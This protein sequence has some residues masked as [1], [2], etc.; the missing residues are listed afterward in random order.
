MLAVTNDYA[1]PSVALIKDFSGCLTKDKD[2]L[3]FAPNVVS[4]PAKSSLTL[5]SDLNEQQ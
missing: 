2:Q 1:E 4:D 3:Q 5:S